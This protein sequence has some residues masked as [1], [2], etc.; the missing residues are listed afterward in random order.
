MKTIFTNG[1]DQITVN[2][3]RNIGYTVI[4]QNI[5]PSSE[6]LQDNILILTSEVVDIQ[7][8]STIKSENKEA[9]V[10][11]WYLKKGVRGYQAIH[12]ICELNGVYFVPPRATTAN[13]I[14]KIKYILEEDNELNG[15]LIGFFGSAPGV[16]CTSNAKIFS[17]RIAAKGKKVILLGLDLY[18]PGNERQ[19]SISLDLLRPRIT[20][21]LLQ[22]EDVNLLLKQD[23]YLY[24]PGNHDTLSALDYHEDEIEYLLSWCKEHA[25][26]VV[27]DF[28]SIAESAAWYVGMQISSLRMIVTHLRHEYRLKQ[29]M[30]L[31]K[32]LSIYPHEFSLIINRSNVVDVVTP[33]ALA[34]QIGS[35][36]LIEIPQY[37]NY[38]E[39]LPL[40]KK[41]TIRIDEIVDGFLIA[42]GLAENK[43][44]KGFFS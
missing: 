11:Y 9:E 30:E 5:I 25:D 12:A 2:T 44:K 3:L 20:G 43:Q 1:L 37:P 18:D 39:N 17:K 16:G 34:M 26:V 4:P 8:L 10:I 27:A 28:G 29:F 13:L 40:G 35:E 31:A 22:A 36:V 23:G 41:E 42:L 6:Q 32:Q 15:N 33:K 21:K 14:E 24:L 19:T 38:P 7:N